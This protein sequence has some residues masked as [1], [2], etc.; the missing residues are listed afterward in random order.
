[1][2]YNGAKA[3]IKKSKRLLWDGEEIIYEIRYCT[4]EYVRLESG[5]K[6]PPEKIKSLQKLLKSIED[7]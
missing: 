6:L 4:S 7:K 2:I 5:I 3:W 1:M